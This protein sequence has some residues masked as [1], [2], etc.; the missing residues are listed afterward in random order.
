MPF[1][2]IT[3]RQ[4]YSETQLQKISDILHQSLTEEFDVPPDDRFQVIDTLPAS[5]RI[6]DRHYQS[7]ERSD[8]FILFQIIAGKPRTVGQ[9][10]SFYRV[11]SERLN[12]GLNIH[13]D[14][15]MVIIQFNNA[16]DWSFSNGRMYCPG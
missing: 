9:K 7:G 12:R 13:P 1:S 4:G 2:R 15:V 11:L 14:D 6:F 3:L 16:A 5:Q 8:N 10:Q